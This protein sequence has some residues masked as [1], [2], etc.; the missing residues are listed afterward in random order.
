MSIPA[1]WWLAILCALAGMSWAGWVASGMGGK[2]TPPPL[3]EGVFWQ[4]DNATARPEGNWHLLGAETLVVQWLM[5]DGQAWYP[6][7][8]FPQWNR[9]PDWGRIAS[10]PWAGRIVAGLS[11]RYSEPQARADLHRLGA[12]GQ[13][14]SQKPLPFTP[15]AFYFPVE[16]DPSWL[17]VHQL[18]DTLAGLPRPLW[19]SVYAGERLPQNFDLWLES[20]L[21]P[22]V[23]VFF[24]D[25]VGVGVRSPEEARRVA[26]ALVQRFG[27]DRVA[28][29]LEAFQPKSWGSGFRPA[30]LAQLMQQ[31]RAYC[32]LRIYLFD[33]PHY[34]SKTKVHL[35][36]WWS[37]WRQTCAPAAGEP[38]E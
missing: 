33:G 28:I 35:W 20:W 11:G 24:Q 38:Q 21:P 27:S 14:I 2:N 23:G 12:E 19:V 22:D 29:V 36:R 31:L 8:D 4:P 16:A 18:R 17:H 13:A 30:S 1:R 7:A 3:V 32:G 37:N 5:V 34:L 26:D 25:G 10:E 9:Q 15:H 6:S